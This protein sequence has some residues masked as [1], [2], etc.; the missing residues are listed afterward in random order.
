MAH[1]KKSVE[2]TPNEPPV[3]VQPLTQQDGENLQEMVNINNTYASLLKQQ[4]QYDAAIHMLKIRRDQVANGTLKLPVM[5][6][7][8]RTISYAES[9]KTKVL[10]HLDDELRGLELAKQGV[11]GTLEYRR[12]NFVESLLRVSKLLN[13]KSKKFEVKTVSGIDPG[14]QD[15]RDSEQKAIEKEFNKMLKKEM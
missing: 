14:S 5:I 6:Q 9:D 12:D 1:K 2:I 15:Q 11:T 3:V 10:K 4:A 8:T 7:V 13:E